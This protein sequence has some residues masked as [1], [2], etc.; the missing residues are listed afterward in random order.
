MLPSML[1]AM[2][3]LHETINELIHQNTDLNCRLFTQRVEGNPHFALD[4]ERAGLGVERERLWVEIGEERVSLDEDRLALDQERTALGVERFALDEG[5]IALAAGRRRLSAEFKSYWDELQ[6]R[7]WSTRDAQVPALDAEI[8]ACMNYTFTPVQV[9]ELRGLLNTNDSVATSLQLIAR[10]NTCLQRL[11][12]YS[13][14]VSSE[15]EAL[16]R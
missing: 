6:E 9:V 15:I 1:P 7:M 12:L 5:Q 13:I 16:R 2:Q 3:E 10:M 11:L 8:F 4:E 14:G